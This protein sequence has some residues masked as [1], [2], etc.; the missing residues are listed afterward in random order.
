MDFRNRWYR[1]FNKSMSPANFNLTAFCVCLSLSAWSCNSAFVQ[2]FGGGGG[3][4]SRIS[5]IRMRFLTASGNSDGALSMFVR[6]FLKNA[7]RD[8]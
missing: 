8:P 7:Y 3:A 4:F 6:A 1:F 5:K 2:T